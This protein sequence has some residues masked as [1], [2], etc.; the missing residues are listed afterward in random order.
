MTR[1]MYEFSK[2]LKG[3]YSRNVNRNLQNQY[4]QRRKII[5]K[6]RKHKIILEDK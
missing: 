3:K 1:K 5:G 6:D 2:L 4:I